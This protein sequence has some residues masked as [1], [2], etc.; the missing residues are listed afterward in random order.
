MPRLIPPMCFVVSSF[1]CMSASA[2]G[3]QTPQTPN[4][5]HAPAECEVWTRELSFA[6]TVADHDPDAFADH[7][8]AGAVFGA[9]RARQTRGREAIVARWG[10]IIEGR[11]VTIEWYPVRTTIGGVDGIAWSEGPSLVI[12]NPGTPEAKY[13]LGSYR[14]VWHRDADGVW[15]VLFDDG[16]DSAPATPEQVQAFRA[17]RREDCPAG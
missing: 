12:E 2:Q 1:F 11:H 13:S 16:S 3:Q 5:A 6:R 15:R 17:G 9:G 8:A 4:A 7:V 14:S 10:G